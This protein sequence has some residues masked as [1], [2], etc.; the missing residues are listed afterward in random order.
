MHEKFHRSKNKVFAGI[1]A[2]L[3][4]YL[5][6]DVTFLRVVAVILLAA[7]G[8]FPLAFLYIIGI[9]LIPDEPKERPA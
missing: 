2:G 5:H 1:V 8:F 6:M 3:A 9:F 4:E 7:T